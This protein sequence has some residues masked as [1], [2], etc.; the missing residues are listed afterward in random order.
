MSKDDTLLAVDLGIRSGLA[1]YDR[2]AR[3]VSYRST[4]FGSRRRLKNAV[5]NVVR[6][7]GPPSYLVTEGSRDLAEIWEKVATK[8]HAEPLRVAPETWRA[9]LLD[10]SRRRSGDDAKEAADALARRIIEET[11]AD[12]PTSLRHDA[13]E[14]IAIGWW[15][16]H[17]VGWR[18]PSTSD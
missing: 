16:C 3:L 8:Q 6:D 18:P 1:I 13:A 17:H 5:Y 7:A 4:N 2:D 10:R 14:A 11:G 9:E 12:R 15:A